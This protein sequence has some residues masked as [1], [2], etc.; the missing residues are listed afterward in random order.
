MFDRA[1]LIRVARGLEPADTVF[2]G[3]MVV[4]VLSGECYRADVAVHD[5]IVVGVGEEYQGREIIDVA[6][7]TLIPGLIEGH[8]HIESTMLSVPEFARVVL[9]HGT[10]TA[11]VDPHEIANVLGIEGIRL[12]LRWAL[13]VPLEIHVQLPSCVPASS[14]E[15]AGSVLDAEALRALVGEPGVLGV[16]E[17]MNFPGTLSGDP[18]L[19]A[20]AGLFGPDGHVDGH[21]PGLSG[22]DLAAYV[23]AGAR[24]DH[25]S[26]AAAEA[27]EKLRLGMWLLVREGSTE[28][29]LHELLPVIK[30]LQPSRSLFCS[31]DITPNHLLH[32]GHLDAI[33]RQAVAGGLD[34]IQAIRMAT[35]NAAQCFG[36]HRRGAIAPG[37]ASD[38]VV[39]D[40]LQHFTALQVYKGGRLVARDGV[41]V[42][43]M[44]APDVEQGTG[45]MRTPPLTIDSFRIAGTSDDAR[46]IGIIPGQIITEHLTMPAPHHAGY[47]HADPDRDLA[48]IAVIERH[49]GSGSIGL[50]L[51][52]GFGLRRGALASSVAHDAHNLVVVG[53]SDED[54]LLAARHVTA[55]G[56]G[57]VV[58][59]DGKVLAELPLP[60]AGLLSPLSIHEVA[61]RLDALDAAA[62]ALGCR[63]EH[64][65]MTLSFLALSVIPALKLTDQGLLDVE[66]FALVALQG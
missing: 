60:I 65:L 50:G 8:I 3:G 66:R 53:M 63:L 48:K 46:V 52:R 5:G 11:V 31:D 39:V 19:L 18:D 45:T 58:V 1:A 27:V 24:T 36:L 15:T 20:K 38:I 26:T 23:V 40:D 42:G 9:T 4:N 61:A 57:V 55:T 43:E 35:I 21:A 25:E 22:L 14:F 54:M 44:P 62:S 16:G 32:E 64:P 17:L 33:L 10:T 6:G 49:S 47:L 30:R 2:R 37:F 29:N 59:A 13:E 12:M 41:L 51:A 56:G 28:R 7:L 34:P